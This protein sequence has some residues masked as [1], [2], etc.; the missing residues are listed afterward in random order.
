[1]SCS[2]G[3]FVFDDGG[4]YGVFGENSSHPKS[5][6]TNRMPFPFDLDMPGL[7]FVLLGC[8]PLICLMNDRARAFLK[9]KS[10]RKFTGKS[11]IKSA[12]Y[13]CLVLV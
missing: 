5:S 6:W 12:R 10:Y 9:N 7:E 13:P 11:N 1:V 3:R 8:N 4:D 2:F